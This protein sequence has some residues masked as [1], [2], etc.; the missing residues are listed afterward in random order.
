MKRMVVKKS[1]REKASLLTFPLGTLG[2]TTDYMMVES[3]ACIQYN[4]LNMFTEW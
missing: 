4:K 1:K 2:L 3:H